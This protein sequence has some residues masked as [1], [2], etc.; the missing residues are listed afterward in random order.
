MIGVQGEDF[1]VGLQ[2]QQLANNPRAGA[3]VFF[4]G[5]VRDMT[6]GQHVTE[7]FL[8]HYPQM[9]ETVLAQVVAQASEQWELIDVHLI[10]RVGKLS[11]NEQIV[12]V[13]VSA[14]HRKNAF[15]AAAYIMDQLKTCA[16]FWKKE[17]RQGQS[18]WLEQ[19]DSDVSA[20]SQWFDH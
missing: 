11:V 7:L 15:A 4:V 1:D 2:Y 18:I 9:T 12:F 6:D 10:H 3:I 13:G 16:P 14:K 8:E 19:R 20:A 5:T 17:T